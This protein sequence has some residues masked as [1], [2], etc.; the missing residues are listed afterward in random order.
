MSAHSKLQVL[1][2][3]YGAVDGRLRLRGGGGGEHKVWACK[4][5][6]FSDCF[7][8]DDGWV[9]VA[10]VLL[11]FRYMFVMFYD[12]TCDVNCSSAISSHCLC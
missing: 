3:R 5:C 12:F 11:F 6:C 8:A 4:C 7:T 9:D 2:G 1:L 10:S